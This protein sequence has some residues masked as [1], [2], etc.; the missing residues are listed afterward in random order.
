MKIWEANNQAIEI[1]KKAT[2]FEPNSVSWDVYHHHKNIKQ[3]QEVDPTALTTFMML[4]SSARAFAEDQEFNYLEFLENPESVMERTADLRMLFSIL[5]DEECQAEVLRFQNNLKVR[6]DVMGL[7]A[8]VEATIDDVQRLAYIRRDALL[9]FKSLKI[10]HFGAGKRRPEKPKY[11]QNVIKFWNMNSVVMAA[12]QQPMDGISMV[13]V[14]DPI[15]L[16]SYFCFLVVNGE[17]ISVI[18]DIADSPHPFH[19]YMSRARAQERSY[20][21]RAE[22][23]R[24]PY[25]LFDFKFEDDVRGKPRFMGERQKSGIAPINTQAVIV[26]P[27]T[28]LDADQALWALMM[29]DILAEQYWNEEQK[30]VALSYTADGMRQIGLKNASLIIPGQKT[31]SR[32]GRE[33]LK[34]EVLK[35]VFDRESTGQND[36]MEKRYAHL[37]NDDLF[38]LIG[39]NKTYRLLDGSSTAPEKLLGDKKVKE[40]L[41]PGHETYRELAG[42]E[43]THF[44]TAVQMESDRRFIA[45]YNQALVVSAHAKKEFEE[46]EQEIR[47]WYEKKVKENLPRLLDAIAKGRMDSETQDY[48]PTKGKDEYESAERTFDNGVPQPGN[49]LSQYESRDYSGFQFQVYMFTHTPRQS[50]YWCHLSGKRATIWNDFTPKTPRS[51]A[52]MAGCQISDLPDV[53]QHWYREERYHGNQILDRV[54]PMEWNCKNPWRELKFDVLIGL[55]KQEWKKLVKKAGLPYRT[56]KDH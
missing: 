39:E 3:S 48:H 44:G 30:P 53:L 19:K 56:L 5:R 49:I 35:D 46:R 18:S 50:K 34:K 52:D 31:V 45:R 38:N 24:F 33:D 20:A 54:D 25:Q 13:M 28:E 21:D 23:L 16:F 22:R 8:H 26:K 41:Y 2:G 10:H 17:N 4:R 14:R 9:A 7:R 32:L 43:P 47:D 27:I 1:W 51:V 11:N 40:I 29:F 15:L 6:A 36:W 55:S 42:M 12:Q 37:V